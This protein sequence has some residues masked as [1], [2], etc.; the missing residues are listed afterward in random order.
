MQNILNIIKKFIPRK[1]FSFFQPIYHYLMILVGAIIYRFPS[2]NIYVVGITGT[3]GKSTTTEIMNSIFEAAGY[4]TALSNTIRFKVGD[5]SK[6]NKYKMSMPGRFF[7]Q[8]FIH[9]AVKDDC[10]HA[11]IEMTSEGS[12]QFRHKFIDL[13][14]FIFT[15]L[16]PEHIESHGSYEKY[17]EAKLSIADNLSNKTKENTILV[18]NEDDIESELFLE[19]NAD[20]KITYSLSDAKPFK[21]DNSGIEIRFNKTTFYSRTNKPN[22]KCS[23]I[24]VDLSSNNGFAFSKCAVIKNN[25]LPLNSKAIK[26]NYI[27]KHMSCARFSIWGDKSIST[28]MLDGRRRKIHERLFNTP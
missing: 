1:I 27:C 26:V 10:T 6:P 14:A 16:S 18:A 23:V 22:R 2:K 19:K 7:M 3:K 15:N 13:D 9:Q 17:R 12:K 25:F 5:E 28:T 11:I 4:K 8:K 21:A 24:I 20:K